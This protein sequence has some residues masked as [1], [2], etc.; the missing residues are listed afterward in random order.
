MAQFTR[1]E[2]AFHE[3]MQ[4]DAIMRPVLIREWERKDPVV[5]EYL[6]K[7][8]AELTRSED[9]ETDGDQSH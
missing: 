2:Q 7:M 5:A 6:A 4:A 1:N 3:L 9:E 8:L